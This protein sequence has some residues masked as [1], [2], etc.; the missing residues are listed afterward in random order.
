MYTMADLSR[1]IAQEM[2]SRIFKRET[3]NRDWIVQAILAKHSDVAGDDVDFH[4]CASRKTVEN[5]V[6]QQINRFDV[7]AEVTP[8]RQLVLDGFERLQR[9][10]AFEE[11]GVQVAVPVEDM[12]DAQLEAK[13]VELM[14]MGAGCYQH[15][16]EI[17]RYRDQRRA[18]A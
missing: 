6:R 14:A 16:D 12:T 8:D 2:E 17:R 15:A 18:A 9:Y 5:A 7:K 1:E 3:L 13:E 4:L 11:R 10:Y